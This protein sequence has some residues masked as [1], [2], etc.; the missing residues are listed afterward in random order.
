MPNENNISAAPVTAADPPAH[1]RARAPGR[2]CVLGEHTDYNDGLALSIAI[3]QGVTVD[4][5]RLLPGS[6]AGAEAGDTATNE[7]EQVVA[8]AERVAA[9]TER[10][11]VYA[12]D[13][14]ERDEFV[15]ADPGEAGNMRD[16]RA[17]VRG[18]VAE[19]RA[20]GLPPVGMSLRIEGDVPRGAGLSSSAALEVALALAMLALAGHR[21]GADGEIGKI[22]RTELAQLCSRVENEWAGARTGLLDQLSSLYG[23]ARAAMRIDFQTLAVDPVPLELD[24]WRLVT[25]DTGERRENASSGYNQRRAECARACELLGVESLRQVSSEQLER[26]PSPLRGRARHVL[27][28]NRRVQEAVAA[29]RSGDLPTVAQ[30]LNEAHTSLR[31]DMEVSTPTVDAAVAQMLDSGAAGARLLGGGFGGSVLGL[32]PPDVTAPEGAREVRPCDGARVD[33]VGRVEAS[34]G[35]QGLESDGQAIGP[36]PDMAERE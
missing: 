25:A 22:G 35:E 28:E 6:A 9:E 27:S 3:A 2:V 26:L 21:I 34:D 18:M 23:R 30:L 8:G 17:F 29:L 4:G 14:H 16:W 36:G 13:L 31:D 19:L 10:I 32:L 33:L 5:D 24:G 12:A 7:A 11:V 15:L 1:V 20:A